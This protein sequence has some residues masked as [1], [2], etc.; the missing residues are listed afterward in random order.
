MQAIKNPAAAST[1]E[2]TP[3]EPADEKRAADKGKQPKRE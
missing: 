3:E 2:S 1:L